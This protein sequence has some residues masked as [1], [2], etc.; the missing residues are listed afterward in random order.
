MQILSVQFVKSNK[1]Y[2]FTGILLIE[3]FQWSKMYN[4][5]L[6]KGFKKKQAIIRTGD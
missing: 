1:G 6:E 2:L 3:E 4:T 5:I